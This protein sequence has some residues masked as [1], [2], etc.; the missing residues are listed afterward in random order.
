MLLSDILNEI[1]LPEDVVTVLPGDG[2]ARELLVR[3]PGVDKVSFTGSTAAG[4]SV[5]A[6]AAAGAN[7]TRASLE[8][9]GTEMPDGMDRGVT[10]LSLN[11]RRFHC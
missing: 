5:A 7:L 4:R 3:H 6:A 1:E 10:S 2:A 8:I 11:A 9:G